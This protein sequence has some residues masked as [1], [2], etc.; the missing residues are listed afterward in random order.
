MLSGVNRLDAFEVVRLAIKQGGNLAKSYASSC[1]EEFHGAEANQLVLECLH[2]PDGQVRAN[3]VGQLRERGI[4]GAMQQLLGLIGSPDPRLS[5]AAR[6]SLNEFTFERLLGSFDLLSEDV[7]EST[8]RLVKSID[9]RAVEKLKV[10]FRSPSRTRRLRALAMSIAMGAVQEVE[11][12]VLEMAS[13]PDLFL[14]VEAA[15]ALAQCDSPAAGQ[16]LRERLLD[17]SPSVQEAAEQSLQSFADSATNQ[18]RVAP[19]LS[20][21]TANLMQFSREGLS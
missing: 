5:E 14:R 19:D 7:A 2:D 17:P 4:P 3:V 11:P 6:G 15:R 13:D 1:L 18:Q 9:Q 16:L 8:G 21:T 20:E 10:E 12:E